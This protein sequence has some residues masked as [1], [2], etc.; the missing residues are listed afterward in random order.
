MKFRT[1]VITILLMVI[2]YLALRHYLLNV[3]VAW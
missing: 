3:I 2:C 1:F